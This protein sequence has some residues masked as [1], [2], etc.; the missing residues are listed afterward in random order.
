MSIFVDSSA[1]FCCGVF[2]FLWPF[3]VRVVRNRNFALFF[4]F[5]P[6]RVFFFFSGLSLLL[7]EV[8]RLVEAHSK[9]SVFSHDATS[10]RPNKEVNHGETCVLFSI[11]LSFFVFFLSEETRVRARSAL[12]RACSTERFFV[13]VFLDGLSFSRSRSVGCDRAKADDARNKWVY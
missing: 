1:E 4:A 11:L 10:I 12:S 3:V 7:A 2:C 5:T 6:A 13:F 9:S 8:F